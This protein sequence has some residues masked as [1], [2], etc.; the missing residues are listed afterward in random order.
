MSEEPE[1]P[2]EDMRRC[3]WCEGEFLPEDMA[4]EHYRGCGDEL[5]EGEFQ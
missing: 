2:N 4:G 1:A 3:E 5:F